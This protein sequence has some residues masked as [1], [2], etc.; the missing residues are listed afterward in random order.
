MWPFWIWT[1]TP[2]KRV[3]VRRETGDF[4]CLPPCVES[5]DR[6]LDP[7]FLLSPL[8]L[9]CLVFCRYFCLILFWFWSILLTSFSL[10][11]PFPKG[12]LFC[13]AGFFFYS[14]YE[15][16][17]LVSDMCSIYSHMAL[18]LAFMHLYC[19]FNLRFVLFI[20]CSFFFNRVLKRQTE[21][22]NGSSIT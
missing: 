7:T 16:S 17:T 1:Q 13:V 4:W 15:M 12:R 2:R 9:F 20:F 19:I 11:L 10:N 18:V 3:P 8:L 14:A 22:V 21:T 5:Q 6:Q